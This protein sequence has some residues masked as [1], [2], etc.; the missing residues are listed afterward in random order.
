MIEER[1]EPTVIHTTVPIPTNELRRSFVEDVHY[2]IDVSESKLPHA[3]ILHYVSNVNVK[4]D[5]VMADPD[6]AMGIL[7]AYMS[8]ALMY[9]SPVL[10]ALA[11][12]TILRSM[13]VDVSHD[14]YDD[15]TLDNFID[16]MDPEILDLWRIRL[17][18][19]EVWS[20]YVHKTTSHLAE[21]YPVDTVTYKD[22]RL[23]MEGINFINVLAS[24]LMDAFIPHIRNEDKFFNKEL[25][26]E[27]IFAARNMF[28]Y[29][30]GEDNPY[31]LALFD[32]FTKQEEDDATLN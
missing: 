27:P 24:P 25:F 32:M 4:H 28:H 2:V 23:R 9:S 16:D 8:T 21:E 29:C 15:V 1:K 20:L 18:S 19:L 31:L 10:E 13:G 14:D 7:K 5:L 11:L 26:E 3:R 22:N 17:S 12:V 6:S 30:G